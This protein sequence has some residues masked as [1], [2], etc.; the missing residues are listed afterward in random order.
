M[1]IKDEIKTLIETLTHQLEAF[2]QIPEDRLE[3]FLETCVDY[4][5]DYSDER[6]ETRELQIVLLCLEAD[7]RDKDN[8]GHRGVTTASIPLN[9]FMIASMNYFWKDGEW[10]EEDDLLE[11]EQYIEEH[12]KDDEEEE[13]DEG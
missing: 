3:A 4:A 9:F 12:N 8:I 13:D 6:I 5:G 10:V 2:E 1:A 7:V 11:D